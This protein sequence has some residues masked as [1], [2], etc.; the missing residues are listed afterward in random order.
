MFPNY[1]INFSSCPVP[2]IQ[3]KWGRKDLADCNQDNSVLP[4]PTMTADQ[5]FSYYAEKFGFSKYQVLKCLI[6]RGVTVTSV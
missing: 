6:D 5:M 4:S 2:C 3:M 1:S